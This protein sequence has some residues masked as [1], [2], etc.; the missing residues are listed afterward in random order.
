MAKVR[1]DRRGVEY[2]CHTAGFGVLEQ[3]PGFIQGEIALL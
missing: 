3:R 2:R 1:I